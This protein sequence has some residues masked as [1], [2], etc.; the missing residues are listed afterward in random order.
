VQMNPDVLSAYARYPQVRVVAVSEFQRSQLE[1]LANVT[2]IR[3]GIETRAFP[4]GAGPGEYLLF[5][6]RMIEDKG[7][8]EAIRVASEIGMPLVM[9]GP[10]SEH[11]DTEV[12]PLVDG[13]R[14]RH[15]GPVS[16]EERNEL[17]AGA[18]ALLFPVVYPEPFGLVTVEAMACGT[19]VA[20]TRLGAVPEIVEEGVTGSCADS[21]AE[22]A[23]ATTRALALDRARVRERAVER[24][25][26]HRMVDA[27]EE[28]YA[29]VAAR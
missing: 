28:L 19:P 2:V 8:A 6:G 4:F 12:A 24:F 3:N 16:V 22:L 18:A 26:Y 21:P 20:A 17:L 27:Y 1:G 9:A 23:Q 25:D 11:F 5:L 14:V 7:P 10:G 15:L 13:E 29:R